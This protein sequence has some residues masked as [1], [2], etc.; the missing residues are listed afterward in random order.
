MLTHSWRETPTTP[1]ISENDL[2]EITQSLIKSGGGALA[3]WRIRDSALRAT[4]AGK[5]LQQA[6][7]LHRLEAQIHAQEIKQIILLLRDARVE[8][9]LVKGWS[10]ARLY[11]EP[12]LRHYMDA[13][14]CVAPEQFRTAGR[15]LEGLGAD[16][17]YVDLHCGLDHLDD[18]NWE[19]VFARTRLVALNEDEDV[20]LASAGRAMPERRP[21]SSERE[22]HCG[23]AEC[24]SPPSKEERV[25][26]LC[27]EDH[28]RVVS[29][30]WLR[31]GAWRPAGLCDIALM[32]ESRPSSFD[33]NLCL[34]GDRVR[35]N[36]VATAIALAHELLGAEPV[37]FEIPNSKLEVQALPGWLAPAVL[38]QWGRSAA[39]TF[40]RLALAALRAKFRQPRQFWQ[41]VYARWDQPVCATVNLHRGFN[42]WPRFPY[43][44]LDLAARI[45][46]KVHKSLRTVIRRE[47]SSVGQTS[48]D[49]QSLV[50]DL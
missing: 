26:L 10:V 50:S 43:Q 40:A 6:Y 11:P 9:V 42:H 37:H 13:D 23:V 19:E 18:A 39:P 49:L 20:D 14:L 27:P 47:H 17:S 21:G 16:A 41:E 1:E 3:W 22:I 2:F 15:V 44:L 31:H 28:L 32:L 38:R 36:W 46:T 5:K 35:A 34:G 29:V 24:L 30:H 25:R 45:R 33:W 8:P 48:S 4:G 7:Q 12:G